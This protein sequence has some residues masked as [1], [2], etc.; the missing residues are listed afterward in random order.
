[1]CVQSVNI[2]DAAHVSLLRF[3]CAL[4]DDVEMWRNDFLVLVQE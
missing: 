4:Y 1:M 2:L 3:S